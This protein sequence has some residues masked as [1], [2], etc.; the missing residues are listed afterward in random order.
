[1]FP[2]NG[3]FVHVKNCFKRILSE[4]RSFFNLNIDGFL[5]LKITFPGF[6]INI[7]YHWIY[8]SKPVDLDEIFKF[9]IMGDPNSGVG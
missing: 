2:E 5:R 9:I 4:N 8:Q 1:M 7:I 3:I 6:F